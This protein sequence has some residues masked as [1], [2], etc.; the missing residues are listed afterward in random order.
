MSLKMLEAILRIRTH[1]HF[2]EKC[3]TQFVITEKMINMFNSEVMYASTSSKD[4][5]DDE[6]PVIDDY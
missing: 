4:E 1:L 6:I 2:D 3:C 5:D